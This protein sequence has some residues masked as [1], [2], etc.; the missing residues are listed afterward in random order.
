MASKTF[1]NT[2][3]SRTEIMYHLC[4]TS[5]ID[6]RMPNMSSSAGVKKSMKHIK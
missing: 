2:W 3:R 5:E 1:E 6:E 4:H